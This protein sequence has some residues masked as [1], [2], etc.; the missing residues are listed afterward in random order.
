MLKVSL[1]ILS[2]LLSIPSFA[3]DSPTKHPQSSVWKVSK[4]G[5]T[6]FIGGTIHLLRAS[7]YP[8]PD[9]FLT[10]YQRSNEIM[11]ETDIAALELPANQFKLMQIMT[12][13]D[14]IT[15]K[16]K[17]NDITWKKLQ[18]YAQTNDFPLKAFMKFEPA[19]ISMLI[20]LQQMQAMG[21]EREFGVESHFN[22]LAEKDKKSI[23]FL[24]S[25]D[26]QLSFLK[27]M[28][29]GDPNEMMMNT[30]NEIDKTPTM[31]KDMT[32]AWRV[33]DVRTLEKIG[34]SPMKKEAH[35]IYEILLVQRNKNW[36]PQIER[37]FK[38]KQSTFILVGGLHLVGKDS[39]LALLKKKGYKI[40]PLTLPKQKKDKQKP[41]AL[42][43]KLDKAV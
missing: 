22:K 39:V 6:I 9:E 5:H 32:Q 4:E 24:E 28:L 14:T 2:L 29:A 33:G 15:A 35:N 7:D 10:A 17:L 20:T 16:D 38:K 30:F 3:E 36:V 8:L 18:N 12:L 40:E 27:R 11:F 1:V 25:T 42:E 41:K 23:L 43:P 13:P 37:I 21:F 26:E 31:I 19:F 34:I